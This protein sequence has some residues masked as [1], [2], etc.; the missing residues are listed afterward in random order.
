MCGKVGH[1]K[2]D[3]WHNK[4][5]EK[6]KSDKGKGKGKQDRKGKGT[7]SDIE[8]YKCEKNTLRR[9]VGQNQSRSQS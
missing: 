7:T 8:C 2:E 6:G 3:S 5:S 4:T 9:T 1:K